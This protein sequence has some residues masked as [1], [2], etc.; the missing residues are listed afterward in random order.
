MNM[1]SFVLDYRNICYEMQEWSETHCVHS[2]DREHCECDKDATNYQSKTLLTSY[3]IAIDKSKA[4][5]FT[6]CM[7]LVIMDSNLAESYYG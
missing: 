6:Y 3:C 5:L 1:H 4:S 7:E 2:P